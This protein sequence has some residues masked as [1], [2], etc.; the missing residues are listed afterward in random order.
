MKILMVCLGN[1]CRSPMAHGIMEQLITDH[2]LPWHVASAGTNGYHT[3]EAPHNSSI[4]ICKQH[5]I[6]ISHQ[7]SQRFTVSDFDN[8]DRIYVMAKDVY[9]DV[10]VLATHKKQME[11]VHYFLDA[12]YPKQQR[13]VI[14]P[15]YGNEDGYLP[16]FLQI[17]KC[18]EKIVSD[19]NGM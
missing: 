1:I 19:S 4:K 16:V 11:K 12:L 15:W 18:C 13:D 5:N 7:V 14:D 9:D 2:Q 10:Q 6:D 3:G 17:K 8:Y